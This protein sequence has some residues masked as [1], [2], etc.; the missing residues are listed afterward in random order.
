MVSDDFRK[1][2]HDIQNY[3][4]GITP[5]LSQST[6]V[7]SEVFQDSASRPQF[8]SY[9]QKNYENSVQYNLKYT[10]D[11]ATEKRELRSI[12][13]DNNSNEHNCEDREVRSRPINVEKPINT[14]LSSCSKSSSQRFESRNESKQTT[15]GPRSGSF[16]ME[17]NKR[18]VSIESSE[19][20]RSRDQEYMEPKKRARTAF[21]PEQI[22]TLE[23]EFNRNKYLAVGRRLEL[24]KKLSLTETQVSFFFVLPS[25]IYQFRSS[26]FGKLS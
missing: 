23:D 20:K 19:R 24:S 13:V 3:E 14:F 5:E 4:H 17:H 9:K 25:L 6:G 18:Q 8:T 21:T 1:Q 16:Q 10:P 22:K 2:R 7:R 15:E 11:K 26:C 12:Q